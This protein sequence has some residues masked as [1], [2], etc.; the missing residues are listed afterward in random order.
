MRP[1][2]QLVRDF[3]DSFGW[4]KNAAGVYGDTAT[5]LDARPVLATYYRKV[6]RRV[7]QFLKPQ[8]RYFLDAGSGAIPHPEYLEYS[9]GYRR[10]VCIDLSE[11]AL[12]EARARL[13]GRGW[14]VVA[15]LTRL[16]FRD[17]VFDAAVCAHVLYH[18]PADEQAQVIDELY[19]TLQPAASAVIIYAWPTAL[20][21][22]AAQRARPVISRWQRWLGRRQP[23]AAPGPQQAQDHPGADGAA[24][25]P[26]AIYF[27][28]HDYDWFQR[29]LPKNWR[30]EIR[31]W[32]AV[33]RPFTTTLIP[34]NWVGRAILETVFALETLF[35]H[36]MARIG[37]Y[38]MIILRK[39]AEPA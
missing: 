22:L 7:S 9:A 2:K 4:R 3:Y 34:D 29:T 1:E 11:Q 8:G 33:D 38:P 39:P 23:G 13:K 12:S 10:R 36:A 18:V 6:H 30:T 37:K 32:R 5:F 15:D 35:P 17:Q 16:P 24:A 26:P 19:R 31:C 28:P 21:T 27:H 14:Y 20:V 25:R